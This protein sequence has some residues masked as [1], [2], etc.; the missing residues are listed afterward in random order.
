MKKNL[1]FFLLLAIVAG[2]MFAQMP[3]PTVT[4]GLSAEA[5]IS[6]IREST[7]AEKTTSGDVGKEELKGVHNGLKATNFVIDEWTNMDWSKMSIKTEGKY[8]AFRATKDDWSFFKVTTTWKDFFGLEV[9]HEYSQDNKEAGVAQT[10]PVSDLFTKNTEN[11]VTVTLDRTEDMG[12]KAYTVY[13]AGTVF[14][15]A[16]FNQTGT[17]LEAMF[18]GYKKI[19]FELDNEEVKVNFVVTHDKPDHTIDKAEF[20]AKDMFGKWTAALNSKDKIK[21]RLE[22]LDS[23]SEIDRPEFALDEEEENALQS[24]QKMNTVNTVKF[25]DDLS[26]KVAAVAPTT[27][28]TIRDWLRGENLAMA[29][30][31]VMKDIAT[32]NAGTKVTMDY[33][34][35]NG[36]ISGPSAY[37]L[38][39]GH[40]SGWGTGLWLD[41]NLSELMGADKGLFVS[42]DG[43]FG[44]YRAVQ[45]ESDAGKVDA[46]EIESMSRWNVYGETKM[47]MNDSLSFS[48]GAL[49]SLGMGYDYKKVNDVS[50]SDDIKHLKDSDTDFVAS[51]YTEANSNAMDVYKISPLSLNVR[52][53]YKLNDTATVWVSNK[54][55]S[56]DGSLGSKPAVAGARIMHGYYGKDSIELGAKLVSTPKS[57]LSVSTEFN[58]Y[59][60]VPSASNIYIKDDTSDN[61][62]LVDIAYG[63]WKSTNFNPFSAKVAY[64]YKY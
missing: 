5:E 40:T 9:K 13:D 25:N 34:F 29:A 52:A 18:N 45:K 58:L 39:P 36:T 55:K 63:E 42:V 59:L 15:L 44:N 49:F 10:T 4:A 35:S 56:L 6:L 27:D 23:D 32:L 57:T 14:K 28:V 46:I 2:S 33:E 51:N 61:K 16:N 3:A 7:V 50:Y 47:K 26:L 12:L 20:T 17:S 11:N 64:T 38:I 8:D 48:A 60:G 21:L 31:Y 62:K 41:A 19:G 22:N 1:A 24:N 53:D 43:Q 30:T 37:M 54:F